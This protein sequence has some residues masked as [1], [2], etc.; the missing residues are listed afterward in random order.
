MTNEGLIPKPVRL[1]TEEEEVVVAAVAVV[2]RL[3]KL[4]VVVERPPKVVVVVVVRKR[5]GKNPSPAPAF[6]LLLRP[7][8]ELNPPLSS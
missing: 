8:A 3:P 7:L 4:V 1:A 2:E 5:R 6:L